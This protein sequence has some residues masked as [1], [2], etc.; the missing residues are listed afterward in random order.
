MKRYFSFFFLLFILDVVSAQVLNPVKWSFSKKELGGPEYELLFKAKIDQGW[1]LYSQDI[2]EGGPVRTSFSIVKSPHFELINAVHEPKPEEEY[3]PNFEMKLKYFSHEA[4]FRQKMKRLSGEPFTI[5]GA[6]EFMCCNDEQCLPPNE[7]DFQFEFAAS[8]AEGTTSSGGTPTDTT[9]K[10]LVSGS[11][12]VTSDTVIEAQGDKTIAASDDNEGGKKNAGLWIFILVSFLAG[13]AGI[14]TPCVF[15]MI[16]M[17]VTF[18]LRGSGNR[19]KAISKAIVFG[20]SIMLTYTLIGVLVSLTSLGADFASTLSTHWLP[21][22]IFFLLFL[23]FAASFFGMFEM[24][25]PGSLSNKTDQQADKGGFIG[26]FFMGLT[27]VIVSFA[28]T[29]PIVGALLVEAAGGQ[30][31]KPILG[32][33][34]FGLAFSLPFTLLAMFPSWLKSMPKSGGWLNSVK[35]VLG[36]IVL[37]FGLKF[38]SNIDQSYHIG[39]LTRDLYLAIWIVIFT[40]MGLYLLGIIRFAHD[41]G[42]G[43]ITF[44]KLLLALASLSFVVYLIP[45]LFGAPLNSISGLIPP[46][47]SQVFDLNRT[48]RQ[49]FVSADVAAGLCERPKYA[50]IF[51]LPYGLTGYFDY[52]QGLACAKKLN[53]PIFLDFKGHSC[54]NC[55]EVEAK[56]W[57]DPRVQKLLKEYLIIAL[58]VDDRTDLPENEWITSRTDGKVKKTIG[59]KNLDMEITTFGINSQPYYVLLDT[60][61]N[62][63]VP[64]MQYNLDVDKYLGFLEKGLQNFRALQRQAMAN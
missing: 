17:T 37:A 7:V 52:R 19:L 60:A 34:A 57:S 11:D 62:K 61:E 44:V 53:K 6:L 42:E 32:M 55:K 45:G 47:T 3:D 41:S 54:S 40:I 58:Y 29:G 27:T 35:I 39:I 46:A 49:A 14:L 22:T 24:I 10:T 28:C 33:F 50:D 20:L 64:P 12:A 48:S 13:L 21:N 23:V 56:V 25:L 38:L 16:P 5:K 1:H 31:L 63:L 15:P 4:I 30:V 8:P 2:P 59:K 9:N 26:A 43:K 36:L 51:H 18:F